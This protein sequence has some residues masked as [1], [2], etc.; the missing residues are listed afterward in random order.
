M[1]PIITATVG[2]IC[3]T[4][5]SEAPVTE[6]SPSPIASATIMARSEATRLTTRSTNEAPNDITKIS[7]T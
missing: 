5:A 6:N 1:M 4:S 3:A 2:V 7:S